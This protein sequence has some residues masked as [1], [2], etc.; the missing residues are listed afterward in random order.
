[1]DNIKSIG[2]IGT[3]NVNIKVAFSLNYKF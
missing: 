1:M 2:L 3:G